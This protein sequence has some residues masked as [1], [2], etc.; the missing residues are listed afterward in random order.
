MSPVAKTI[1]PVTYLGNVQWFAHLLGDECV[2]DVG[3][4]LSLIH[5]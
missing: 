4:Y 1:L 5:I 2:V 3:E